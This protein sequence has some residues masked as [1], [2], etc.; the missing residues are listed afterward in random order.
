M[1]DLDREVVEIGDDTPPRAGAVER[2]EAVA[3]GGYA[4]LEEAVRAAPEGAS[5]TPTSE[6]LLVAEPQAAPP[7]E[8]ASVPEKAPASGEA[9]GGEHALVLRSG[10]RQVAEPRPSR[11]G[12]GEVFFGPPTQEEAAMAAVTR[13]L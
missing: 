6:A 5:R 4:V 13:R 7:I 3:G 12:T 2:A 8:P 9:A 11:S 10:E 1:V